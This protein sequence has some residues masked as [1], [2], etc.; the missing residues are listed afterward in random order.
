MK[1]DIATHDRARTGYSID[2][3]A[4]GCFS[5]V[6]DRVKAALSAQGFGVL[7]EIDVQKALK[8]KIG[9]QITPYT[10]LGVC[11]PTL[12]GQAID[13]EPTIGVFLPCTVLVRQD[14]DAVRVHAQDPLLLEAL[15]DN[16]ALG[17]LA[18]EAAAKITVS[19][20]AAVERLEGAVVSR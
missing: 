8:D 17:P 1:Q 18:R 19:L 11:N 10:I 12:A 3:T 16:S 6:V 4:L 14:G 5:E 2:R 20:D 9:K 7:S 13:A 15:I